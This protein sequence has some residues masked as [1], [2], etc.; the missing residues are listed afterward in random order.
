MQFTKA[1]IIALIAVLGMAVVS[2]NVRKS[3]SETGPATHKNPDS[4]SNKAANFRE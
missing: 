4:G 1:L 3:I 2:A